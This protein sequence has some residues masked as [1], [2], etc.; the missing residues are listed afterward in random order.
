M[1]KAQPAGTVESRPEGAGEAV[2]R[3]AVAELQQFRCGQGRE[4]RASLAPK[5]RPSP[6]QRPGV[7]PNCVR[8]IQCLHPEGAT[9]MS[10]EGAI[11]PSSGQSPANQRPVT[12]SSPEGAG[13]SLR[14]E[15]DMSR[16]PTLRPQT[17]IGRGGCSQHLRLAT[18]H[19]WLNSS[20]PTQL[21]LLDP[22]QEVLRHSV[23][24]SSSWH[25]A[26]RLRP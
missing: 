24:R 5:G 17:I 3:L 15:I 1:A 20:L 23:A 22:F 4:R 10:P 13:E 18:V 26:R 2:G 12:A 8:P 16:T 9:I 25:H 14:Q 11:H 19:E 7:G 21:C 6:G